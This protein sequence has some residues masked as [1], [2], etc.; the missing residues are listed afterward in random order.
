[1]KYMLLIYESPD[2]RELF[3]SDAGSELLDQ[4]KAIMQEVTESGELI[5]TAALADAVNAKSV[6]A[7]GGPP[8][9]T[10]GPFVESKEQFGGYLLLDCDLERALEIAGRWPTTDVGGMEVRALMDGSGEEM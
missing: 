3:Q 10:D 6:R 1:M 8:V 2:A 5:S 7:H 9:I 4:V